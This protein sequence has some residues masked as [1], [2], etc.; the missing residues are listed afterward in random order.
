VG[1]KLIPFD[2]VDYKEFLNGI[3]P[4]RNET[5]FTIYGPTL[6]AVPDNSTIGIF[7]YDVVTATDAAG[8][9]T[10]KQNYEWYFSYAIHVVEEPAERRTEQGFMDA[11]AYH[12]AVMQQNAER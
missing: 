4:P 3:V 7:L 5:E 8:N 6:D 10:E 12:Q 11:V 1:G 2:N 9:A